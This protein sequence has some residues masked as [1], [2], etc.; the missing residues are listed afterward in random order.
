MDTRKSQGTLSEI[1]AMPVNGKKEFLS[2]IYAIHAR[3]VN[4]YW[5]L[6][7]GKKNENASTIRAPM[8]SMLSMRS[9]PCQLT[10]IS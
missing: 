5:L 1:D 4:S 3:K 7:N 10:V 6:V 8:Q 2:T 9:M